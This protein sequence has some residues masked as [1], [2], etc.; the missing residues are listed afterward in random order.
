VSRFDTLHTGHN[1]PNGWQQTTSQAAVTRPSQH[2]KVLQDRLQRTKLQTTS[3][4][5]TTSIRLTTTWVR[6]LST[7]GQTVFRLQ[8]KRITSLATNKQTR[9]CSLQTPSP[10]P[11]S[12]GLSR[13]SLQKA[14]TSW[15]TG[16]STRRIW[17][18]AIKTTRTSHYCN[19]S[20]VARSIS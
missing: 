11:A 8:M 7:D 2:T 9:K 15:P 20:V 4:H 1:V 5:L 18:S 10:T 12:E 14:G 16:I 17:V 3:P 13:I 19:K 6:S